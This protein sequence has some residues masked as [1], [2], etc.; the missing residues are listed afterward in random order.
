MFTRDLGGYGTERIRY[1]VPNGSTY[2][3][4]PISNCTVPV[5]NRFCVNRVDSQIVD[6]IPNGSDRVGIRVNVAKGYVHT[7]QDRFSVPFGN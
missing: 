1:L 5:S 2:E 7:I 6:P 3:G 4:D